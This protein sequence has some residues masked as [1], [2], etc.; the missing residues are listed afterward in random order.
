MF[1]DVG[2]LVDRSG[3]VRLGSQMQRCVAVVVDGVDVGLAR[4]DERDADVGV[5]LL[6]REM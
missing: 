3:F 5:A 4:V 6:R 2:Q 1:F